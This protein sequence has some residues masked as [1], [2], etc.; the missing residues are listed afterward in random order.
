MLSSRRT[1]LASAV[2]FAAVPTRGSPPLAVADGELTELTLDL[3]QRRMSSGAWSAE[4]LTRAYLTR[5]EKVNLQGPMLRALLEVN[6]DAER[7]ARA[8]DDERR[9]GR[10]RGPLHGIPIVLKD[11][12]DTNDGMKTTAGSVVLVDAP[13]PQ[14]AAIVQQLRKAGAVLLGKAN[15]SEWANARSHFSVSGWSA[16]GGLSRNPYALDRSTCGSSSGSATSVAAQLT[17]LAVGTETLGSIQCPAAMTNT[18]GIKPS[19]GLVSQAGIIPVSSSFDTA[20]PFARSVKDAATLLAILAKKPADAYTSSLSPDALRGKRIGVFRDQWGEHPVARVV[21]EEC[22]AALRDRGADVVEAPIDDGAVYLGAAF[23]VM[24]Y[25]LKATLAAYLK[26]RGGSLRT[27]SDVI[28]ANERRAG[29]ELALFGQELFVAANA[30]GGLSEDSYRLSVRSLE[31]AAHEIAQDFAKHR[32]DAFFSPT[33]GI[34]HLVDPVRGDAGG[35]RVG[36]AMATLAKGPVVTVPGGFVKG[37]PYG[38]NFEGLHGQ[39]AR[40]IA[41]ASA[42]EQAT[43]HRRPPP[44]L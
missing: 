33:T 6:T 24:Q 44:P 25:E 17:L 19:I 8:L 32:I 39:D 22:V 43:H 1:F 9:A 4:V 30:R 23:T 38:V 20:G 27:L 13:T 11:N 40:I 18:V 21:L 16:R 42:F 10:V 41:L 3:A 5:I 7:S 31:L 29:E 15:M 34:P 2:A 14:D 12:I 28:A 26:R 35:D 36:T 37:L